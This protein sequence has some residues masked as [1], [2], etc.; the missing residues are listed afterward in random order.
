MTLLLMLLTMAA[1]FGGFVLV[2]WWLE[3]KRPRDPK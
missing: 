1:V 2:G 3:P